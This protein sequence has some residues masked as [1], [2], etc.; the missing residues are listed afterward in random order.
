MTDLG[1]RGD[2]LDLKAGRP[3]NRRVI[4]INRPTRIG[5]T[6]L[7]ALF[8]GLFNQAYMWP[9]GLA[10]WSVRVRI[11]TKKQEARRHTPQFFPRAPPVSR[12]R[13]SSLPRAI[14]PS[15]ALFPVSGDLFSSLAHYSP[16]W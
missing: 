7:V 6:S 1:Y 2:Q 16:L 5:T 15:R 12:V 11:D 9:I 10:I 13:V 14:P 3:I 8:L 4:A